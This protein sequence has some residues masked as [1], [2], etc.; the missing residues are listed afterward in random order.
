MK[1]TPSFFN[2][3]LEYQSHLFRIK[4]IDERIFQ[5]TAHQC[6]RANLSIEYIWGIDRNDDH[7]SLAELFD[8]GDCSSRK[9]RF[10]E[11]WSAKKM[12]NPSKYR[13]N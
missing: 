2:K 9:K 1:L 8:T 7:S 6:A 4:G 13:G 3:S 12:P 11:F 5:I 10:E